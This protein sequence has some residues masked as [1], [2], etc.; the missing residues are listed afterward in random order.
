MAKNSWKVMCFD[1]KNLQTFEARVCQS[2][3]KMAK[4]KLMPTSNPNVQCALGAHLITRDPYEVALI[5][6]SPEAWA[7]YPCV[8]QRPDPSISPAAFTYL[9]S[10]H[11]CCCLCPPC[12]TEAGTLPPIPPSKD[13][14]VLNSVS[15]SVLSPQPEA[16]AR[17]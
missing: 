9:P 12:S 13:E 11:C 8:P 1:L 14:T 3:T 4:N 16:P 2:Q 17:A 10:C 5:P 7:P 6:E 15:S